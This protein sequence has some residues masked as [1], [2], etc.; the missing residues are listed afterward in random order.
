MT[1]MKEKKILPEICTFWQLHGGMGEGQESKR[2]WMV[3]EAEGKQL[4]N[5][6]KF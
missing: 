3:Q 5:R 1:R 2:K 6:K 4:S